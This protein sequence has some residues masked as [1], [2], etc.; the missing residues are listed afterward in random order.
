M[1]VLLLAACSGGGGGGDGGSSSP[2][3][4]PSSL[5]RIDITPSQPSL[6]KGTALSLTATGIYSDN[7]T[8]VLNGEV[9]WQSS[10]TTIATI[11]DSGKIAAVDA[12]TVTIDASLGSVSAQIELDVKAAELIQLL[13]TPEAPV[14]PQGTT[15]DLSARGLY[16]DG[17]N[18]V[19]TQQVSWESDDSS[20]VVIDVAG[21]AQPQAIGSTT[22]RA[23]L[24]GITGSQTLTVSDAVLESI[25]VSAASGSLPLAHSQPLLALGHFSDNRLQDITEQVDWTSSA[26]NILA[27]STASGSRGLATALAIG[28]VTITASLV[29]TGGTVSGT[30]D[31]RV[32]AATLVSIE[33][34]P[35]SAYL[36]VGTRQDFRATGRYSDDSIRDITSAAS[37]V[38]ADAGV[39]LASNVVDEQGQ[40][41]ALAAGNTTITASLDGVSGEASLVVSSAKLLSITVLPAELSLPLSIQQTLR[42]E[43]NFSDGSV[44]DLDGQVSWES[45]RPTIAAIDAGTLSTL[46]PGSARISARLGAVT[47][48]SLVTVN[49]ATLDSLRIDPPS[50]TLAIGTQTQLQAFA[51]DTD[52]KEWDV[53]QQVSWDTAIPADSTRLRADNSAGQQGQLTALGGSGDV[54]VTA[55]LYEMQA[56]ST[57]SISNASLSGL[58]ITAASDSLDSAE[59]QQLTAWADFDDS[60]SQALD[61]QVIWS[62]DRPGLATVSNQAAD[63][64]RVLAG[65]GVSGDAVISAHFGGLSAAFDLTISDT[66]Q[67]PV[68]LV[69]LATP[70][71]LLNNDIDP[72]AIE[73]RVRAADP[74]SSV[75]DGTEVTLQVSQT[76]SPLGSPVVL[77]T[78]DGIASTRLTAT[79]TGLLQIEA[80]IDPALR[81][82]TTLYSTANLFEVIAGAAFDDAPAG[83]GPLLPKDTR[84]GFFM[85]NLSN[86]DFRLDK[87]E[88]FNDGAV[89]FTTTKASD[90]SGN[91]LSGGLKMGIIYTLTTDIT[92]NGIEGHYSLTDLV[93]GIQFKLKFIR[94]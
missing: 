85:F 28:E 8:R 73:V 7:T 51:L 11:D 66:P 89:L 81:N 82:T 12:G 31:Q 38:S 42:A 39:A 3:S 44:Q 53:T 37:W 59:A 34:S 26:P 68:S 60:S 79:E 13:I 91:Q 10:D 33:I 64:G 86:R 88:L 55:N 47:G 40:T 9:S 62:S 69:V 21:R 75:A 2:T 23:T 48:Y 65:I 16:S 6:A 1:L 80:S 76:G 70:N 83:S 63:R 5:T 77:G 17:S 58:R 90:L 24:A 72:S 94:P 15:L 25:E 46:Q 27:I 35:P 41:L 30:L 49:A 57:I 14:L 29:T 87:F 78:T 93:T 36:A 32:T 45:E 67:R 56:Q 92:A 22:V 52:D 20:I 4:L 19:L 74:T 54:L 43:G 61:A 71:A 84:F 18:Q 50:S